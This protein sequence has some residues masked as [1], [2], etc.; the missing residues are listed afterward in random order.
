[1]INGVT[2][3]YMQSLHVSE[4]FFAWQLIVAGDVKTVMVRKKAPTD[5]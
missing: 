3:K 1:M 4:I 5:R 2:A